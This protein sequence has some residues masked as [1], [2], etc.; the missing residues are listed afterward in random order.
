MK[1]LQHFVAVCV[2]IIFPSV[3]AAEAASYFSNL[4]VD[5][6]ATQD[7]QR[8]IRVYYDLALTDFGT[9]GI[10][11]SVIGFAID[12]DGQFKKAPADA[13]QDY[14]SNQGTTLTSINDFKLPAG[15]EG[16]TYTDQS[17]FLP[18]EAVDEIC[19]TNRFQIALYAMDR[20]TSQWLA[21]PSRQMEVC[22]DVA[23][24]MAK[25]QNVRLEHYSGG[26]RVIFDINADHL[27]GSNLV[28]YLSIKDENGNLHHIRGNHAN[29]GANDFFKKDVYVPDGSA[30][31]QNVCFDLSTDA[32]NLTPG[33]HSYTV[34]LWLYD[35]N[36]LAYDSSAKFT[37][38]REEPAPS[39]SS[40]PAPQNQ[41]PNYAY[42]YGGGGGGYYQAQPQLGNFVNPMGLDMEFHYNPNPF[43]LNM[44][45]Q[46]PSSANGGGGGGSS[47]MPSQRL[48]PGT[49]SAAVY[50]GTAVGPMELNAIVKSDGTVEVVYIG[51]DGNYKMWDMKVD[52]SNPKLFT[53]CDEM[54]R[55]VAY[56]STK[57]PQ[58]GFL[59]YVVEEGSHYFYLYGPL[60]EV[61]SDEDKRDNKSDFVLIKLLIKK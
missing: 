44:T 5:I 9:D 53:G 36:Q 42:G 23:T 39:P 22:Y 35:D 21:S 1:L 40:A 7:G 60:S 37:G 14:V 16:A 27:Q 26:M 2:M 12:N 43:G 34:E 33:K 45:F 46:S 25:I 19:G 4:R 17:V 47:S 41:T 50:M 20:R 6:D 54:P 56:M 29:G 30:L 31:V 3:A 28:A 49:Y 10:D 48:T 51:S 11:I 15:I 38:T 55:G 61:S 58:K 24:P 13:P 59:N 52:L 18:F 57:S 32:M 8:G